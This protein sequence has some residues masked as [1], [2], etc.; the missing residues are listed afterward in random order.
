MNPDGKIG[1]ASDATTDWRFDKP[2]GVN[3]RFPWRAEP[4]SVSVGARALIH[5]RVRGARTLF[6]GVLVVEL[7]KEFKFTS[8]SGHVPPSQASNLLGPLAALS[9]TWKGQGF[10]QDLRA[11]FTPAR[12]TPPA[13]DRFLELNQTIEILQF[14]EIP[15]DIPNR[16]LLQADI[17]LH[18]LRYL[19]QVQDANVLGPNGELAGIHVEPGIGSPSR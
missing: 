6:L 1:V 18:G 10:N 3:G 13:Q 9:G 5:D 19:Q 17:N 11:C 7:R 4:S 8:V 16:G 15:G 12:A 14:E 2:M